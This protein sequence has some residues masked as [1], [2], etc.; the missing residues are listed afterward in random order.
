MI[1][2]EQFA[3]WKTHPVTKEIFAELRDVRASIVEQL[4][5]GNT[6]GHDAEATHGFT[7]RAIGQLAGIDQLLNITY[8]N[9]KEDDAEVS[10]Q[11]G[12]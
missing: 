6:I 4:V 8:A 5:G 10:A 1:T 9:E 3:E 11:S 12:Y 7:N 2:A